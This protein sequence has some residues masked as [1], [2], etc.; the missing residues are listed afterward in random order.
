MISFNKPLF[1]G[2]EVDCIEEAINTKISGN[3]KFTQECQLILQ[4]EFGIQKA[5]LTTSGTAALEMAA[6]LAGIGIG[7]E[8]IMPSFTFS[9][10]A[11]AFARLGARIS[12]VDIRPDTLNIDEALIEAAITPHTKAIAP[13]HYAGVACEMDVITELAAKYNLFVIEDAA[14]AIMSTYKGSP[15]GTLGSFG[16]YSFHETK[17]YSMGEGGAL[18]INDAAYNT[19]AEIMW[20]KGTNR[21][22][23]FSGQVDKYTWVSTGSS[24][25]PSELCAAYLSPG[26]HCLKQVNDKR[27]SLW[28]RYYEQ[29]LE[30]SQSERIALPII[31][32]HCEHCAHIFYI[33]TANQEERDELLA[34]LV[35]HDVYATFHYIPLH[36]SPAGLRYGR[37]VGADNYTTTESNRLIRLPLFYNLSLDECDYI[38]EQIYSF[39]GTGRK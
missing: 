1:L 23:F 34:F 4:K 24:F 3:G 35:D 39:Y 2:P 31:P 5:L 27:L 14:H 17:N 38:A 16:C 15:M 19:A 30:L 37:M 28:N 22:Q 18:L 10:A 33:K 9:S 7:D 6:M 36:T 20:E 13:V 32:E 8:V 11:N 29:L 26:L 21:V 25:L 12:F